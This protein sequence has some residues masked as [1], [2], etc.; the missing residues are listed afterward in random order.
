MTDSG[1]FHAVCLSATS[2]LLEP[3][4]YGRVPEVQSAARFIVPIGY[5]FY[6]SPVTGYT[7]RPEDELNIIDA[8][9]KRG[10]PDNRRPVA[11]RGPGA[12]RIVHIP[13]LRKRAGHESLG[14]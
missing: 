7:K 4:D 12:G 3:A 11:S 8:E 5:S 1:A 9:N 10:P 13:M 14:A 2:E 6:F